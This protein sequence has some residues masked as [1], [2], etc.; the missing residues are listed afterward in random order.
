LAALKQRRTQDER[1]A[2][3]QRKL[4]RA[5]FEPIR[6]NGVANFRVAGVTRFA[7]VSQGCQLHH[8]PTKDAMIMD[9]AKSLP[10]N[11]KLR[12]AIAELALQY[13]HDVEKEWFGILLVQGWGKRDAGD[14][15]AMTTSLVRGFALRFMSVPDLDS[16][17]HLMAQWREMVYQTFGARYK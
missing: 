12:R 14:L 11:S 15:I 2:L 5:A 4:F 6:D 10:K 16:A 8:F 13:R 17:V 1:S 9:V 3:T 7:R